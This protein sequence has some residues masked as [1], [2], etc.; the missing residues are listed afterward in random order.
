[1]ERERE[2]EEE[3]N[4]NNNFIQILRTLYI[5]MNKEMKLLTYL[6]KEGYSAVHIV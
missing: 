6:L 1:M 4:V 2:R 3:S 5:K